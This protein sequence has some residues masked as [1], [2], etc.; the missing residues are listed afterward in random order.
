MCCF[1]DTSADATFVE[2]FAIWLQ[3]SSGAAVSTD[4]DM[5]EGSNAH[6]AEKALLYVFCQSELNSRQKAISEL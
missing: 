5:S 1:H 3:F 4:I 2:P 6:I